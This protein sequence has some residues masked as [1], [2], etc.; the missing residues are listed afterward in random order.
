[1][2]MPFAKVAL[3]LCLTSIAAKAAT[4]SDNFNSTIDYLS[5]GI[6]GT[7]WDGV[8]LGA[9][10]F[11][12]SGVG[13]GG[14]GATLKLD[15]NITA[16][17]VLSVQST[18]TAWE[19]ADDD[20]FF[21]YKVM[22]GDF[23]VSVRVVTPFDNN[24]FNTAGLQVRAFS[25][26][27]NPLGGS[28]DFLS[29]TRFDQFNFPNYLRNQVNGATTQVNP[30]GFPNN[31][32]WLRIDRVNGTNFHFYQRANAGDPW[33]LVNFPAPISGT[34]IRRADFA[35]LPLQVGLVHATFSDTAREARFSDF[36][37]TATNIDSVSVAPNPVTSVDVV[38]GTN[39]NATISWNPD[40]ASAGTLVTIWTGSSLLKQRPV[41]GFVYAGDPSFGAGERLLATNAY[42]VYSGA[43]T[44]AELT[45][46]PAGATCHVAAYAFSGDGNARAYSAIPAIATFI[47]ANN[48]ANGSPSNIVVDPVSP[49]LTNFVILASWET[50]GA[51]AGWTMAGIASATVTNGVLSGAAS[52]SHPQ[53]SRLN[54]AN[55]PNLNLGF[56]DFLELQ[57]QVPSA[58]SGNIQI[59]YGVTTAPGINA[60]RA[61]T[62][63]NSLIPK[64]GAL[65][66]Y[67]LE[68]GLERSWRATLRDLRI[69]PLGNAASAGQEFAVGYVRAGDITGDAYLPR[70]STEC[71]APGAAN[72]FGRTVMSME[73]KHFRFLWDS[74]VASHAS[75]NVNMPEW[76]L[77]NLEET[78]QV[79][80]N[81]LGYREP[82][83]SWNP[84]NR[85]GS[86]YKVN[87][88]TWHSGYWAGGDG[89]T[90]FG[91]INITPDGL[92]MD[93]PSWVIPHELMHV[94]QFHQRDGGQAVDGTWSEGQ[95]N[96][97]RELW[98]TF[99]RNLFPNDSGIDA[100]YIHSAHMTVAH[101]RDYYLS[102]PFF[103][104]LDENPDALTDLGFG[105]MARIW[106]QNLPGVYMYTTLENLTPHSNVKDIIGYFARRQLTFDYENQAAITNALNSQNPALWRRFITTD[107]VRRAD[108]INWWRVPMEMAPMQGAYAIHDLVPQ[109]IGAGRE[110]TV[111][112]RGLP[113]T[114]RGA[115]WR[116]AFIVISDSGAERY[117][118]LWNSGSN[119]VTLAAN[120]NRVYLSVAGTPNSVQFT[121]FDDL[122]YPYRS[123]GSKQRLHYELQMFGAVPRESN[124]GGTSGLIQHANGGGWRSAGALVDA[125]AYIG[126]NARV[127]NNARVRGNARVEDFAVVRDSATVTNNGVV[128]GHA[129]VMNSAVIRDNAKV[130]D[131]AVVSGGSVIG[132]FARVLERAQIR[133]AS[134]T[135]WGVAKGSAI[136]EG[137]YVAGWGV[138][139]GDFQAGRAVTNGFAFGHLPFTGVP[140]NWVRTAPER[141]FAA[142]EFAS[143]SGPMTRDQIGVTDAYLIGSPSWRLSESGRVGAMLFSGTNQYVVLDRSLSDLKEMT[144]TAWV[145]WNGGESNQPVWHF[146]SAATNAMFLTPDDGSGRARFI[147]RHSGVEHTLTAAAALVPGNWTH[148]VVT[149][150]DGTT[151]RLFMNGVLQDEGEI[152]VAPDAL[153]APNTATATPHQYLARGADPAQPMFRGALDSIAIYSRPLA[154]AEIAAMV[155]ANAAPTLS[156]ISDATVN[157]G[158]NVVVTNLAADVNLP[159]QMLTFTL[160]AG[161]AGASLDSNTG[162]FTWRPAVA[163]AGT[164]QPVSVRVADNGTPSLAATQTFNVVINPLA[165]PQLTAVNW[166]GT[167]LTLRVD[168]DGGPDYAVQSSTNLVDWTTLFSTNSPAL[169]LEFTDSSLSD[170]SRFYRV[171]LGP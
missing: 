80:V 156:Q 87:M 88:I 36:S 43:G 154:A 10:E 155:P 94:F 108:D 39:R 132:D 81:H 67:R 146:G 53:L 32:Y 111:N 114:T 122:V 124:N 84:A 56:N 136:L 22:P 79:Y 96:Y 33:Q 116:A 37:L 142:Y 6:S 151:G 46:L 153:N 54:F 92:R 168:G 104:Y 51:L 105:T 106:K 82:A 134:V 140:N 103:L 60:T 1:M 64:D 75:W 121:G 126:P 158:V 49:P 41:D 144:I 107:L 109:G 15:A 55:G 152:P 139:D 100:N 117:S 148:V 141:Q 48:A 149:L 40:A 50:N 167:S 72:T 83:E 58:F 89:N 14:P 21:L 163:H 157:V 26:G 28:E 170:P 98:I 8:Y 77:R 99:Y 61:L 17:G 62:I 93:P 69:D 160:L 137:G 70:Y 11:S 133:G 115:D 31:N 91:Y 113:D 68:L 135:N 145:R 128:S 4:L 166:T 19:H 7:I 129:L 45:N 102:W 34:V 165:A 143:A 95:A 147:L 123:H 47:V 112:F 164:I 9:G 159:W 118:P 66:V 13:G 74:T 90:Q 120:E 3:A 171:L 52:G 12:N 125:S 127:L 20:G 76:T 131:W 42:V 35:G 18:G 38:T 2:N 5:T 65:H 25:D 101:G 150:S 63:P 29:W 86:K 119:S 73:S 162:V 85:N 130:R 169:P 78:W 138:I 30:G 59:Y 16:S 161:P 44:N 97:G 24:S 27:G 110:V 71:P 57:L 23:S